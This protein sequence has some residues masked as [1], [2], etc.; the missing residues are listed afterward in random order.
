MET[1][2]CASHHTP[3][4]LT[5]ISKLIFIPSRGSVTESEPIT[6]TVKERNAKRPV[7]NYR[8]GGVYKT[9]VGASHV[10]PLHKGAG[11]SSSPDEVGGGAQKVLR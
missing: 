5:T 10:L 3:H 4:Q 7:S 6:T 1:V 8:E 2:L 9:R 11:I